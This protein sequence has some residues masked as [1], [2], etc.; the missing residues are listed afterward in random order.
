MEFCIP[1][2]IKDITSKKLELYEKWAEIVQWGRK[3]PAKFVEEFIG[4]KFIDNQKYIFLSS[5]DKQFILWACSRGIGKT[6]LVAPFVMAKQLLFS[7]HISYILSGISSQSQESFMKIEKIMK[8]QIESFLD[9]TDLFSQEL[10]TSVS[11]QDGITHSPTGFHYS[12]FNGSEITSLSSDFDNLRGKRSNLNVYDECG[13]L[14]ERLIQNSLPFLSVESDFK[15]SDYVNLDLEPKQ[16]PNQALMCSSASDV[17]QYFFKAYKDWSKKMIMGDPNYFV[18]DMNAEM[19]LKP[20]YGGMPIKPL[21]SQATIDNA[22][23]DNKEKAMREYYNKFSANSGDNQ[24]IK[25]SVLMRNTILKLPVFYND[26][27]DKSLKK[28]YIIAYDPAQKIDNSAYAIMECINEENIGWSGTFVNCGVFYDSKNKKPLQVPRQV[29]N[30]K[31]YI[32]KYNGKNPDYEL[33]DLFVDA[34]SGGGGGILADYF[35][36]DWKDSKGNNHRGLIDAEVSREYMEVFPNAYDCLHL[37]SPSKFKTAMFDALIEYLNLGII[38]FVGGNDNKEFITL[39]RDK[40][41]EKEPYNY[42]L[43]TDEI[44]VYKNIEL[45]QEELINIYRYNGT[46]NNYR[47]DLAPDKKNRNYNDDRAYVA[48]LCAWGLFLLKKQDTIDRNVR[49]FN[50][51][52]TVSCVTKISF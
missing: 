26:N 28:R 52:D 39:F 43:S 17:D 38:K 9:L 13:F 7:N 15:V 16:I 50:I 18:C 32:I 42:Q 33:I 6:T 19:G 37:I 49:D 46:N 51:S 1:K 36:E 24:P 29:K 47:Y 34:G 27:K 4:F 10:V 5:W 41:G 22:M 11:N 14:D 12:L 3:S 45:M 48:A 23:R 8:R 44:M 31:E 25:R 2:T 40:N 35:M 21:L 30:L 20:T